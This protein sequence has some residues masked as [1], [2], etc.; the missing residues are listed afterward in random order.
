MCCHVLIF[1]NNLFLGSNERVRKREIVKAE[2]DNGWLDNN[3][4]WR[5]ELFRGFSRDDGN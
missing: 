2:D 4:G 3:W 5:N 1:D